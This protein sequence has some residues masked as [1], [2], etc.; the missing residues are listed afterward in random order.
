MPSPQH[1][2]PWL[3]TAQ[4]WALPAS[5]LL[6]V[7]TDG[8]VILF[9]PQQSVHAPVNEAHVVSPPAAARS[10]GE[11][12]APARRKPATWTRVIVHVPQVLDPGNGLPT[13]GA[14]AIVPV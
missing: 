2:V 5:M 8:N 12:P 7:W 13:M 14:A 1:N 6:S 3:E 9:F 10:S 4:V 11:R